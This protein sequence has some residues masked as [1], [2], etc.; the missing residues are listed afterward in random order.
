MIIK[1][2]GAG[3]WEVMSYERASGFAVNAPDTSRYGNRD[4]Q[5]TAG[6]DIADDSIV[7][8]SAANT[9]KRMKPDTYNSTGSSISS[10]PDHL[11][12]IKL[13]PLSTN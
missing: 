7:Y 8:V 6:E 1:S 13:F 2:L 10:A 12:G 3:A 5:Y 9:V 4:K 11:A